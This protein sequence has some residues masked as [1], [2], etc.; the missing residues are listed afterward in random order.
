MAFFRYKMIEI[1]I[2]EAIFITVAT[3]GLS[4]LSYTFIEIKFQKFHNWTF[5]KALTPVAALAAVLA[6]FLP[7]YINAHELDSKYTKPTIGIMSH[8]RPEIEVLG[9]KGPM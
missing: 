8:E 5:T 3:F 2:P 9:S 1:G 7:T 6:F 4:Y